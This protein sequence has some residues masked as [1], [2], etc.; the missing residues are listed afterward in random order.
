MENN[1]QKQKQKPICQTSSWLSCS[2][3]NTKFFH[4]S[5]ACRMRYYSISCLRV[6]DGSN[7][8]GRENIGSF[9]VDHFS[10]LFSSSNLILDDSLSDLVS[11]VII[12][13]DNVVLCSIP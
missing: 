13:D 7:L 5:V 8:L 10:T 3:F 9:L 12:V 2:D 11:H 4:A 1:F 6:A